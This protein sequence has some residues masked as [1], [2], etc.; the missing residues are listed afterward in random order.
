MWLQRQREVAESVEG[1][2]LQE[3][4]SGHNIQSLHPEIVITAISTVA[5]ELAAATP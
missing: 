5:A 3:V 1:G 4:A 2:R